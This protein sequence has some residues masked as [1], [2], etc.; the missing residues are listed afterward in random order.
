VLL[1]RDA[2]ARALVV[3]I[4][5]V[6]RLFGGVVWLRRAAVRRRRRRR[7]GTPDSRLEQPPPRSGSVYDDIPL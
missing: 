4:A 1:F 3:L 5:L 7:R 6:L 2:V